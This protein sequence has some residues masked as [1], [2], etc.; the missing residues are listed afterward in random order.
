MIEISLKVNTRNN[1]IKRRIEKKGSRLR[2]CGH[3]TIRDGRGAGHS[4][5]I[6]E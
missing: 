4:I 1:E 2:W 5:D 6:M 3:I